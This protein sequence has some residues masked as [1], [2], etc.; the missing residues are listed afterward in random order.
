M[1]IKLRIFALLMLGI[2]LAT[3]CKHNGERGGDLGIQE[4]AEKMPK[5]N[6]ED[7]KVDLI[8]KK[9]DNMAIDEKIGQLIMTGFEGTSL[10]E[11]LIQYIK[12]YN[13]GGVIF[14]SRNIEDTSQTIELINQIKIVNQSNSIPLLFSIDEEGGRVS[15][16]PKSIVGL[17]SAKTIGDKNDDKISYDFGKVLGN[18]LKPFGFNMVYGPVLD[19]NSN[20]KNPVIGDRAFGSNPLLVSNVGVQVIDGI[21]STNIIS[22][23]KHFPGHGDTEMDS[24]I[25]LPSL[26]KSFEE[27]L[28]FELIPFAK[29]IENS[30]DAIMVAHILYPKIDLKFPATMSSIIINDIL[31]D[32]LKF[33]GLVLSDDMTMGAVVNNF[34][35]EEGVLKFLQSGGDIALI[36]HGKDNTIK[37]INRILEAVENGELNESEIDKKVY[38]IL[39]LKEKY[40]LDNVEIYDSSIH[41]INDITK[42]FNN[43]LQR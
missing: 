10:G 19:I 40:R 34:T 36:C 1:E 30:V 27:L 15:R 39:E 16:F 4:P 31:R 28:E 37:S 9:I 13:V 8:Q 11:D 21:K 41:R 12:E 35:V 22:V 33:D 26:D 7:I 42:E 23:V 14:F 18:R 24:H 20:P 5:E 32:T 38:R 17:P 2:L 25:D 3:G 6:D 29:A 43:K